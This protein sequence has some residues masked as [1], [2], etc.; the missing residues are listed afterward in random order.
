MEARYLDDRDV[1]VRDSGRSILPARAIRFAGE[2]DLQRPSVSTIRRV[3]AAPGLEG[4]G[5]CIGFGVV[6]G[7]G[8]DVDW[9]TTAE[10]ALSTTAATGQVTASRK[11]LDGVQ[12]VAGGCAALSRGCGGVGRGHECQGGPARVSKRRFG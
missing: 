1:D 9:K 11:G 12:W 7:G 5:G 10:K 3:P 4:D 6:D 2:G 8:S